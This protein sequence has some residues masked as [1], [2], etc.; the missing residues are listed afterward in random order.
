MLLPQSHAGSQSSNLSQRIQDSRLKGADL[1]VARLCWKQAPISPGAIVDDQS[2]ATTTDDGLAERS[3]SLLTTA[4]PTG[5]LHEEL[6]KPISPTTAVTAK[7]DFHSASGCVPSV[8]SSRPCYRCISYM[9][10]AGIKRVFWT[11]SKGQ[12]EGSK[13]RDLVDALEQS[14]SLSDLGNDDRCGGGV[15][16]S[17]GP[18]GNGVFVTKHEVLMLRRLMGN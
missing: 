17:G 1:Y 14:S 11:N 5:S 13:V 9:H 4:T 6:R 12:W 16:G 2:L 8:S 3:P 7:S 10:S 18:A 15:G